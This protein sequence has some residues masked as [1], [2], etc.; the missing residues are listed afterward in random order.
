MSNFVCLSEMVILE[1][2]EEQASLV[3]YCLLKLMSHFVCLSDWQS[4]VGGFWRVSILKA[5]LVNHPLGKP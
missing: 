5:R 2:E 3:N 1:E 4:V